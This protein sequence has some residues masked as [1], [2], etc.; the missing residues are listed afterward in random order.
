MFAR[1]S[2]CGDVIRHWADGGDLTAAPSPKTIRNTVRRFRDTGSVSDRLRSGRASVVNERTRAEIS[3]SVEMLPRMSGRIRAE[4]LGIPRTT[5]RREIK[6]LGIKAYRCSK[7]FALKEADKSERSEFSCRLLGMLDED[8]NL[9]DNIIWSDECRFTLGGTCNTSNCY[10][11]SDTNPH[12][13]IEEP[14][15]SV[16][17][18]VWCG[19]CSRGLI[20]PFFFEGYVSADSY[21]MMLDTHVLPEARRVYGPANF[22]L[23]QD[24]A[25]PHRAKLTVEY[26]N[27]ILP[28]RWIGL[29]GKFP[30]PS[31]S[32]DLAPPDFGLWGTWKKLVFSDGA[33]KTLELLRRKITETTTY[34]TQPVCKEICHSVKRRLEECLR[35]FG[36]HICD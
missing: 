10:Y 31:R 19:V 2:S 1:Y 35:N 18:M 4:V 7:I 3:A 11:Y 32:P 36:E 34:F 12:F 14:N 30:F 33:I 29:G 26:L 28:N 16:G 25:A 15:I 6:N 20:G 13:V 9:I 21:K 27:R 22:I 8:T 23:Q 17:L 24:G 5:V